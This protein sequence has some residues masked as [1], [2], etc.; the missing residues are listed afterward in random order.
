M[1]RSSGERL[2]DAVAREVCQRDN[3]KAMLKSSIASLGSRYVITLE[4]RPRVRRMTRSP[5][6]RWR[7][8]DKE[9]R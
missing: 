4:A 9:E 8:T 7:P 1:G 3:V 5:A 6:N 2:T